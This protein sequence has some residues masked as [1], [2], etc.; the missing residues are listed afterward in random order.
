MCCS[1]Q[2]F[3]GKP[4]DGISGMP[5]LKLLYLEKTTLRARQKVSFAKPFNLEIHYSAILCDKQ[6][7]CSKS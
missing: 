6:I 4:T 1:L 7:G 2:S 3:D 5:L